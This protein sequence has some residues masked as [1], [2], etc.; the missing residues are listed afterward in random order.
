MCVTPKY[1]ECIGQQRKKYAFESTIDCSRF[2]LDFVSE[3]AA[4]VEH[5]QNLFF[6]HFILKTFR[7]MKTT[8]VPRVILLTAFATLILIAVTSCAHSK[9]Q[10]CDAYGKVDTQNKSI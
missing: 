10:H 9:Y 7:Q 3:Y 6:I 1:L 4:S 5:Q 2:L 8:I